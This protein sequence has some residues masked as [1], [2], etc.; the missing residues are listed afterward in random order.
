MTVWNKNSHCL[1]KQDFLTKNPSFKEFFEEFEGTEWTV[2]DLRNG[3]NGD[4]FAWGKFGSN[5]FTKRHDKELVW[6]IKNKKK[7][8]FKRLFGK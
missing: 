8:F 6:V 7:G 2:A 4:G 1:S 5:Q 3:N